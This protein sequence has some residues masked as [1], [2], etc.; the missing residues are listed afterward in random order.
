MCKGLPASGKSTWAK[1]QQAKRINKDDLRAMFDNSKWSSYNEKFVLKMRDL[2]VVEALLGG[3]NVI[4]DD[5]NL[6]PKHETRLKQL[7]KE[8]KCGFEIK[9]FTDVSVEECIKRDLKRSNSVGEK[10][11]RDMYN[12]FLKPKEDQYV[13]DRTLPRAFIF[14]ID[15]TLAI[16][17]DRSPFE[18]SKVG[19]DTRNEVV[20]LVLRWLQP[21]NKIII[22]SGRDEVCRKETEKWLKDNNIKYEE[23]FMRPEGNTE[24]DSIIKKGLFDYIKTKYNVLGVFDDRNQVVEMWRSLGLT[25]FQVADGNF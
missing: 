9:D 16:M 20:Y 24:K 25:C 10:V 12:Q 23:L 2:L 8:N 4:A 1:E 5:T 13:P 15:G 11:I 18:W 6:H 14:D 7:A 17:G 3:N 22:L 21:E 19:S